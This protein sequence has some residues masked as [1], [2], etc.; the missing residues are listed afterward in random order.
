MKNF[1]T[2]QK[3]AS[4]ILIILAI[5]GLVSLV[6]LTNTFSFKNKL[7]SSL[8]PK[9]LSNAASKNPELENS[10]KDKTLSL[11][12]LNKSYLKESDNKKKQ[13]L[14]NNL[15]NAAKD[16]KSTMLSLMQTDPD[17][18]LRF[19]YSKAA[20]NSLP[21][22]VQTEI[23][24]SASVEGTYII[25]HGDNFTEKK[26]SNEYYLK[27]ADKKMQLYFTGPAP[28]IKPNSRVLATGVML[29]SNL[30]VQLNKQNFQILPSKVL[31]VTSSAIGPTNIKV[32]VFVFQPTAQGI[33]YGKD[34]P[35]SASYVKGTTFTDPNSAAAYYKESSFNKINITGD[36]Y[37]YLTIPKSSLPCN[38]YGTRLDAVSA[39]ASTYM[40]NNHIDPNQYQKF[41]YAIPDGCADHGFAEQGGNEAYVVLY[42]TDAI[43]HEL[44]HT[45][46]A[47]HAS[48]YDCVD[49]NNKAVPISNNCTIDQYGDPFDTMA[50][51]NAH[52]MSNFNNGRILTDG[53]FNPAN[54]LTVTSSG[55]YSL[56]PA[57]AP[58]AGVQIIRI[59][60]LYN[61]IG[62]VSKYYY[63]EYRQSSGA[64]DN[65]SPDEPVVKGVTIRIAP[66]FGYSCFLSQISPFCSNLDYYSW[67]IK[68]DTKTGDPTFLNSSLKQDQTFEDNVAG[69]RIK[70]TSLSPQEAKVKIDIYSPSACNKVNPTVTITPKQ[71]YAAPFIGSTG[72]YLLTVQNNDTGS[73]STTTFNLGFTTN[74]TTLS[75]LM[76]P[77]LDL[78]SGESKQ[79]GLYVNQAQDTPEGMYPFTVTATDSRDSTHTGS[80]I[81]NFNVSSVDLSTTTDVNVNITT[82]DKTPP[83]VTISYPID[84]S[85]ITKGGS[86][87]LYAEAVDNVGITE[88]DFMVN[89]TLIANTFNFSFTTYGVSWTAPNQPGTFTIQAKAFDKAGN[90]TLS[91]PITVT[92]K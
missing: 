13:D 43:I 31:G 16:R 66:D 42:Q 45:L 1:K 33:R 32:A 15:K 30:A 90:S 36:V 72:Q 47:G 57:E 46:G 38:T 18:F 3:G 67:L 74:Q 79:I 80:D 23:E 6:L 55:D 7:F 49:S 40:S 27:T 81:A 9:P 4:S 59:P 82:D 28:Y 69:V 10:V 2:N 60:Q 51:F 37:T 26:S 64:F 21:S 78:A 39:V 25:V 63:L 35:W 77:S 24:Q 53:I 19:S 91:S 54:I 61:L 85:S 20:R 22:E 14:T 71:K 34:Q 48:K 58:S 11:L 75:S 89:G 76:N 56:V 62:G 65:F 44:G 88:V 50:A 73:C 41:V 8:F 52:H 83:T 87:N 68:A 92:S 17:A 70:T 86:T 12:A 5:I 84:G 29:D